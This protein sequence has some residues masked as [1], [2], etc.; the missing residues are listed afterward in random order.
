MSAV[1]T[2][3]VPAP[4]LAGDLAVE[5]DEAHHGISVLRLR[6]GDMVRLCDGAG[7]VAQGVVGVVERHRILIRVEVVSALPDPR[8][9]LITVALAAPKGDRAAD[10]VRSLTELGV[11]AIWFL[12]CERGEREP[13]L[14]R[15]GRV[16]REAVKQCRRSRLPALRGAVPVAEVAAMG[17]AVRLMDPGGGLAQPGTP[18]PVVLVVGPEGGF[19]D[20]ER[21]RL[22]AGG[23]VAVR[24]AGPILRI[25]TAATAAAAVWAAAWDAL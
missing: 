11:G 10:A 6:A 5:G 13:G 1:R 19:T 22:L 12:D 16:A 18:A 2:L 25:E 21:D 9:A 24:L 8:A 7:L 17:G 4:V 20:A 14:E 23:G 15:L 3:L